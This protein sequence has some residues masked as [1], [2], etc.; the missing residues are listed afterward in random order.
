VI[1]ARVCRPYILSA[2]LALAACNN[3]EITA[4]DQLAE[5]MV[6][7][8]ASQGWAFA[9][10]DQGAPVTVAD[11]STSTAW[12]VAFNATSVM[13]NGGA[14]GPGDVSAFCVCQNDGSTDDQIVAMSPESE[15][16]DFD[17]VANV[18]AGATFESEELLPA[19]TGWFTGTG[20]AAQPATEKTWLVRLSDGTSFAKVRVTGIAGATATSFGSVSLEYAV[21]PTASSAFGPVQTVTLGGTAT[22]VDLNTGST[23][24]GVPAWDFRLDGT[25]L[26]LNGGVSGSGQAA[27]SPTASAFA[28]ITTAAIDARAYQTDTFGGVFRTRPWYKYNILGDNRISPTFQVYLVKR[29]DTVYKV[30]ILNYYGAAGEPRQITF[31]YAEL[32][33]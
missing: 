22:D 2:L 24:T 25:V 12:D 4:P 5:G 21:Q 7:I 10:L 19:I 32:A 27:A 15:R 14:A 3:D 26:R 11:P 20:A 30:Q 28:D 17:A 18:P 1:P 9:S 6:T 33:T 31:R 8:N 29:G 16:A 23:A 13:L